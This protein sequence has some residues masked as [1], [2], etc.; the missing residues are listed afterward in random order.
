MAAVLKPVTFPVRRHLAL[1]P[2]RTGS[3][4]STV[5]VSLP[6]TAGAQSR[7][8]KAMGH[9]TGFSGTERRWL[10]GVLAIT[11]YCLTRMFL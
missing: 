4:A 9:E 11:G 1:V 2:V 10:F 3:F 8:S 7:L 6:V 5:R